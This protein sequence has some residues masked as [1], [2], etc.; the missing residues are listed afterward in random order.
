[1]SFGNKI[2][3]NNKELVSVYLISESTMAPVMS[4]KFIDDTESMIELNISDVINNYSKWEELI[5][6]ELKIYKVRQRRLKI[7][8]IL[9]VNIYKRKKK[10]KQV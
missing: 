3:K 8:K 2:V 1:M 5:L 7:N 4:I 9:N 6:N 10:L